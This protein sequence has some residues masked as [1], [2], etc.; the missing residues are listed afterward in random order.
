MRCAFPRSCLGRVVPWARR[1][2][3][4]CCQPQCLSQPHNAVLIGTKAKTLKSPLE[5]ELSR[6][7]RPQK[8]FLVGRT[9]ITHAMP[10]DVH[11]RSPH[12]RSDI[13]TTPLL[14]C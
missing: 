6:F 14:E 9:L 2:L 1:R 13:L 8:P 4:L 7:L 11:F 10:Y 12:P 5:T 3:H